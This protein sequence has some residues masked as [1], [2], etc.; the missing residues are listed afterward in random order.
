MF[1][2]ESV[3]EQFYHFIRNLCKLAFIFI[4]VGQWKV[5]GFGGQ[6]LSATWLQ[7]K[8]YRSH[9]LSCKRVLTTGCFLSKQAACSGGK[10]SGCTFNSNSLSSKWLWKWL[11]LQHAGNSKLV[12]RIC[13]LIRKPKAMRELGL[14]PSKTTLKLMWRKDPKFRIP[15]RLGDRVDSVSSLLLRVLIHIFFPMGG[16]SHQWKYQLY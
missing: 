12:K 5:P 14:S 13:R 1:S 8:T 6:V 2:T 9:H 11:W 7:N 15:K 3:Q 10:Q 16:G 4:N